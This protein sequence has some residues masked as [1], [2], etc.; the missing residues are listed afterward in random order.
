MYKS[1]K[2][3]LKKISLWLISAA[4]RRFAAPAGP[5]RPVSFT[6]RPGRA[7]TQPGQSRPAAMPS[8]AQA[9]KDTE[10]FEQTGVDP[11]FVLQDAPPQQP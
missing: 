6:A 2:K 9:W 7:D 10:P 4:G 1:T 8:S 11:R 5:A 3:S